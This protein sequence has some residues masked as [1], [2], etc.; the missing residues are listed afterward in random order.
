ME[1]NIQRLG[2]SQY[3]LLKNLSEVDDGQLKEL[4]DHLTRETMN[5][6]LQRLAIQESKMADMQQELEANRAMIHRIQK[7]TEA[8]VIKNNYMNETRQSQDYLNVTNLG[9]KIV[10]TISNFRMIKLLKW[11][12]I[13]Q[14]FDNVPYA[15]FF[16]G[17][18]PLVKQI[19][20]VANNGHEYLQY[21][22]H[23]DRTWAIIDNRLREAGLLLEF[24]TQKNT[25]D[26]HNF[27]DRYCSKVNR[28]A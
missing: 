16:Y 26:L 14:V 22:Y 3:D 9:R 24:K 28:D 23:A 10:P 2:H 6:T 8:V 25:Y 18:S 20:G 27:I 12:K 15:D 1:A 4:M 5:R 7:D 17:K 11:A 13:M 19:K 21:M